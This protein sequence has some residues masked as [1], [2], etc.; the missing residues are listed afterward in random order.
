MLA[1]L[2]AAV[3]LALAIPAVNDRIMSL[4]SENDYIGGP[5]VLLNSFAWRNFLWEGSFA[6]IWRQPIFGYGL[7]S[8]PFYSAEFFYP[9]PGG[10]YAHNDYIQVLFETG[11]V[12][13]IAFLWIFWRCAAW[14]YQRWRFDRER[15]D[16][17]R[18]P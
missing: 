2:L 6:Y 13:L 12:G 4:M 17:R 5:T 7:H 16:R 14:L 15:H 3:P 9:T 1:V 11:L 10:T 18:L 8:F